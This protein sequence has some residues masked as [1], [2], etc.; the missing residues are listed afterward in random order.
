MHVFL[1][2]FQSVQLS[3]TTRNSLTAPRRLFQH[4]TSS[5]LSPARRR[6]QQQGRP[7]AG[8]QIGSE[9]CLAICTSDIPL[10]LVLN[11]YCARLSGLSPPLVN[12]SGW[13]R[14]LG[15]NYLMSTHAKVPICD[16]AFLDFEHDSF[17]CGKQKR[18]FFCLRQTKMHEH[19]FS[20]RLN[21][22]QHLV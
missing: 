19:A 5:C 12:F 18:M 20:S 11:S 13:T 9:A 1:F 7:A 10:Q 17:V 22:G 16:W 6:L 4:D 2:N 21:P 15:K 8:S 14:P 3:N